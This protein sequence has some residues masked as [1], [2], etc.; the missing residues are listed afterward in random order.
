MKNII[1]VLF[2]FL[3]FSGWSQNSKVPEDLSIIA[4]PGISY[5]F[6]GE[7]LDPAFGLLLGIEKNVVQFSDKSLLNLGLALSFHGIKYNDVYTIEPST[8]SDNAVSG[9]VKL[10][11]IGLP[12]LYRHRSPDGFFWE[13]GIQTGFLLSGKDLPDGGVESDYKDAVKL[14]DIGIPAGVGYWFNKRFSIGART[15]YG[16]TDMSANGAKIPPS[17][18]NHQNFLVT[19]MF[20]FNLTGK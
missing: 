5:V 2:F 17:T 18:S 19:A 6:G 20:R 14:I 13:V 10:T 11:Y 4:G 8:G 15:V 3:A 12:F 16:L 9:K 7:K 1:I